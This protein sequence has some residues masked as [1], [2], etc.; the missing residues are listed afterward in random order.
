MKK[1]I[2]SGYKQLIRICRE[3]YDQEG[4]EL[5]RRSLDV[6]IERT[7]GDKFKSDQHLV[8]FAMQLARMTVKE[9]GLDALGVSAVLLIQA[10]RKIPLRW[11]K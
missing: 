1:E 4:M 8:I 3:E 7:A 9:L 6:L 11:M 5:I 2:Q 10:W